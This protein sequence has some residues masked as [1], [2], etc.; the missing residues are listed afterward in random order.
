MK[1]LKDSWSRFVAFV[2]DF[3]PLGEEE[4]LPHSDCFVVGK[5]KLLQSRL[6]A[7]NCNPVSPSSDHNPT[8]P[9]DAWEPADDLCIRSL[10]AK[11]VR[12]TMTA[13]CRHRSLPADC[14]THF[15]NVACQFSTTVKGT[16]ALCATGA[17]IRKRLPSA[18][19]SP[20]IK[21][22]GNWN[23]GLGAPA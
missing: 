21:P 23:K 22:S 16:E 9:G 6:L 10:P 14:G 19:T 7:R 13:D 12:S 11:R 20:P 17:P 18:V 2:R 15:F 4:R 5:R 8:M 3:R 1:V